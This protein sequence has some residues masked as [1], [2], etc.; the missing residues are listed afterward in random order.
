MM[1]HNATPGSQPSNLGHLL[2]QY[3]DR[4]AVAVIW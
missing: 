3:V 4:Y 1:N 2:E